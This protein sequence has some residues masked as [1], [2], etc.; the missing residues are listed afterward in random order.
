MGGC[1]STLW[2]YNIDYTIITPTK[3][4]Y[5]ENDDY[6]LSELKSHGIIFG[7]IYDVIRGEKT[8]FKLADVTLP[9][10]Y[11]LLKMENDSDN[12]GYY[13][14]N[15][16]YNPCYYIWTKK[17][18]NYTLCGI[19]RVT[20]DTGKQQINIKE[21]GLYNGWW[22]ANNTIRDIKETEYETKINNYKD[23]LEKYNSYAK[24]DSQLIE[25]E[26]N[27]IIAEY[28][29]LKCYVPADKL[30]ANGI[31]K[32]PVKFKSTNETMFNS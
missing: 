6:L 28:N 2:G 17:S 5:P 31:S 18:G 10:N 12:I 25:Q 13:I 14:I 9:N 1:E 27:K 16:R 20:A 19:R 30:L 15:S 26:F 29:F 4:P 8:L 24:C 22:M 21:N 11:G 32:P 7:K 3:I 23:K